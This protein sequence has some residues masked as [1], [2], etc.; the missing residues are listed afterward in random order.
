MNRELKIINPI[1]YPGWN[2]LVLEGKHY[3]FFHSSNW[4][5]VLNESYGCNPIYFTL[6]DEDTLQALVP[7]MEIKSIFTGRRGVSLPF[8]D[9]CDP[10][11]EKQTQFQNIFDQITTYAK[12]NGWKFLEL[13]GGEDFLEDAPPSSQYLRHYL[14]LS[15]KEEYVFS[16]FR[17]ST[18]RNI[19]KAISEGVEVKLCTSFESVKDFYRINC[20]TRKEHGLP[21]Q[22]Y[23][24]FK[25]VYECIISKDLGFVA[26]ASY[27]NKTIAGS[28]YFH[29]GDKAVY[30]YGASDRRYQHLR[31]NNLVMWKTIKWYCKAG[32]KNFCFGRT[33]LNNPGLRQFKNGWGCEESIISYFKYDLIRDT[34]MTDTNNMT[35]FYHRIFKKIPISVLKILGSFLYKHMG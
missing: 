11:A 25:K 14:D 26:L 4:A 21:P 8:T 33:E 16:S 5:R 7:A 24:F 18:R 2:K 34:F 31:A 17:D 1:M 29:F 23:H 28:I 30:K 35:A 15:Q 20:M 27:K 3:T 9:Y 10:M 32:F 22:P 12:K 13:R 6:F 19:K